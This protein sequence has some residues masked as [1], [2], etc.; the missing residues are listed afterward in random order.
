MS[1]T[2]DL[3]A[4]IE[5]ARTK[6]AEDIL[7]AARRLEAVASD[8]FL[9]AAK[10]E[11]YSDEQAQNIDLLSRLPLLQGAVDGVPPS[12]SLARAYRIGRQ[13]LAQGYYENVLNKGKSHY[14]AFLTLIELEKQLAARRGE[15]APD[16]PE[17][18]LMM[19]CEAAEMAAEEG[20]SVE[21]QIATGFAMLRKKLGQDLN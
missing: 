20:L 11:G 15:Q 7:P 13:Q 5:E 8:H 12:E 21:E 19:A 4:Q 6:I 2:K 9:A 16:Y 1:N 14:T 18:A 10:A 17:S 3:A